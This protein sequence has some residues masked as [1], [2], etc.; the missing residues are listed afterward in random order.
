MGLK[1]KCKDR[2]NIYIF[3]E[4]S[5]GTAEVLLRLLLLVKVL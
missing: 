5:G 2:R 3:F 4:V 1:W